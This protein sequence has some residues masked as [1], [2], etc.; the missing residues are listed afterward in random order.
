MLKFGNTEK[1][2]FNQPVVA[3]KRRNQ[4]LACYR[5]FC[6]M[7]IMEWMQPQTV[8]PV[9]TEAQAQANPWS[10]RQNQTQTPV[11]LH[12]LLLTLS[13]LVPLFPLCHT[14]LLYLPCVS[15]LLLLHFTF[16]TPVALMKYAKARILRA[17]RAQAALHRGWERA[18]PP[19]WWA[20]T[21]TEAEISPHPSRA[22]A[23][24]RNK[25]HRAPPR[26]PDTANWEQGDTSANWRDGWNRKKRET[27]FKWEIVIFVKCLPKHEL[28]HYSKKSA[29]PNIAQGSPSTS[30]MGNNFYSVL[31][32]DADCL[33]SL[34][35]LITC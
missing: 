34:G 10:L 24:H 11:C 35:K 33:T 7:S 3:L 26:T 8:H 9:W 25:S 2:P 29:N 16:M 6:W 22:A 4:P 12:R 15:C 14:H 20:D 27:V 19:P 5:R 28:E 31:E 1:I 23:K 30:G 17:A 13:P 18:G 32:V 21:G